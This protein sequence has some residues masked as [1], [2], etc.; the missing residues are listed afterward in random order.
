MNR[1]TIAPSGLADW[2]MGRG[3]HFISTHEAARLLGV[4]PGTVWTSL[5]RARQAGKMVSVTKGGWVP[6]PPEYRN[7]GAPPPIHYIDPLMKHLGHAYYVG[8]L[9]A[10]ASY[11]ASHQAP[12]VLQVVTNARLRNRRVGRSR[13]QFVRRRATGDR[14]TQRR[15]VPT[16]RVTVSTPETTVLD[17]VE[18]PTV[19]AGL[20]NV[21]TVIGDLLVEGHLDSAVLAEVA[22]TY[23][24][25][26]AQRAGHLI[27]SMAREVGVGIKLEELAQLVTYSNYTPLSPGK[28]A[29]R[30]RDKRWKV[31][32]N[33]TIEHDL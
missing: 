18:A 27:E 21:A 17:L 1:V 20:S 32:I 30:G 9:S 15:N 26:A 12:M 14:L 22:E 29:T 6:V 25:T 31:Q 8:F 7:A 13:I 16:G 11:G 4:D 23:P 2:L 3:Q 24:T 28:P 5:E 33:T 19:G 10:A